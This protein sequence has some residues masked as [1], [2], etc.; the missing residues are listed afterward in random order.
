MA[1]SFNKLVY[2]L[3]QQIPRGY[4]ATYGQIA[5]LAGRPRNARMVGYA[6]HVNPKPGIIPCHRVVFRDGS[7]SPGF[8]F[9]G[10]ER[11]RGLLEEEG[12]TFMPPSPDHENAGDAGWLVDL[13]RSQWTA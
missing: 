7:L 11:Q 13:S 4:V 1:D 9:G 6:L 12:V 10:P 5:A 2:E 8:A 3:V